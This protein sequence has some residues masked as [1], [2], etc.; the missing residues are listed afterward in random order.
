M[1]QN[2]LLGDAITRVRNAYAVQAKSVKL[3]HSKVTDKVMSILIAEGYLLKKTLVE[4][5]HRKFIEIYLKYFGNRRKKVISEI[6]LVSKPG[7]RIYSGYNDLPVFKNNLG[8]TIVSTPIG[9]VTHK[10]AIKNKVGG[11]VLCQIF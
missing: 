10:S 1:T 7:L 8:I 9:I 4:D 2:Y 5:Q 3:L 11:E 6:K